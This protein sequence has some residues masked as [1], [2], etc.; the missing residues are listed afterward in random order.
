MKRNR[1]KPRHPADPKSILAVSL[2]VFVL[3]LA[4]VLLYSLLDRFVFH[5]PVRI[6]RTEGTSPTKVEKLIQVS[7][8]NECGAADMAMVFTSYL[9]RRGFDVVEAT[10]GEV[11]NRPNTTVIDASGNYTNALRV[12]EA[13]GVNKTNVITK[14]DP[15]SYV[16]VEVLI[17]KDFQDLKPNKGTE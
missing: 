14:L 10:N 12:A 17:G 8:R 5:P 13:L 7:V 9:R 15:R 6:E 4:A 2:Q 11:F 1:G 16:D 3:L